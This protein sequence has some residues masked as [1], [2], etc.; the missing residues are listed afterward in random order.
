MLLFRREHRK[1]ID[2]LPGI[3]TLGHAEREFEFELRKDLPAEEVLL[4]ESH[5]LQWLVTV[6]IHKFKI[7]FQV[8][9]VEEGAREFVLKNTHVHCKGTITLHLTSEII[10]HFVSCRV[11]MEELSPGIVVTDT[12]FA[13]AHHVV[14]L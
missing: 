11:N 8:A 3:R 5:V 14:I 9:E 13:E 1:L 4:N 7:E 2:I 10:L 12:V 6:Y